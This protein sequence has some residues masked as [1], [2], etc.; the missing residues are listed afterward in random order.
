ML[1]KLSPVAGAG[2]DDIGGGSECMP[3]TR[4][5]VLAELMAWAT[6]LD[7]PPIY[8]LTGLAGTGK[9]AIA[10]SFA[11]LL[12]SQGLLGATFFCS[13]GSEARSTVAEIIPTIAF[14]LS[15][16]SQRFAE[17]AIHAIKNAPGVS[18]HHR[19]SIFQFR[20]LILEPSQALAD[21]P[22]PVIIIDALD[23]CS[24]IDTTRE[25]LGTL[26]RSGSNPY[27]RLK[28]FITSRPEPHIETVFGPEVVARRLR[29]RDVE[30]VSV[31]AD[32]EKYLKKKLGEIA[33]RIQSPGWPTPTDISDLVNRTGKLFIFAFTAVQYLSGETLSRHEIQ[34]RLRNILSASAPSKIQTAVIDTLYS[35][36]IDAAWEGKES[37]EKM[38][39]KNV[40]A[41]LICLREPL[42][43][44]GIS[45]LLREDPRNLESILA[46]F[47][48]VIDMPGSA[49]VPIVIFHASFSDY[50]TDSRRSGDNALSTQE[51]H[52]VLALQ[53]L[54]CMNSLLHT[55]MCSIGRAY[56][57]N[58]VTE[59]VLD[60]SVP[61]HLRYA[62]IHW[63]THLPLMP[64]GA[65]DSTLNS[66][67]QCWAK[68]HILHW[69]EC[70]SLIDKL[71]LAPDALR[72]ALVFLSSQN[73][74]KI[75]GLLEEVLRMLP[76]IFR[77][78]SLYPLEVYHSAL[79]WLPMA[80]NLRIAYATKPS[81]ALTG[82][83]QEW[84][85]CEQIFK[86]RSTCYSVAVSPVGDCVV[87]ATGD[88][89][90]YIWVIN[91]GQIRAELRGHSDAV[92]SVAY[93]SHAKTIASGSK[94]RTVR[95]WNVATAETE[96]E[97]VGHRDAV[98][99]V[100]FSSNGSRL[101]SAS[102][103]T[104]TMVWNVET[105]DIE[106]ILGGH[107]EP[108]RSIAFSV[109]G[110]TLLSS[111]EDITLVRI[112]DRTSGA[113]MH[114]L[115]GHSACVMSIAF[116][117]DGHHLASGSEDQTVRIWNVETAEMEQQLL[118]HTGMVFSVAFS[119]DGDRLISASSDRTVRI[120]NISTEKAQ[121]KMIL[122]SPWVWSVGFTPQTEKIYSRSGDNTVRIWN[123]K[124][125]ELE[126][127][128][129]E[130]ALGMN[131]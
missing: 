33:R 4:V 110:A 27:N 10:R 3:G 121:S 28:F 95:L 130:A 124:T 71:H 126:Q 18:F 76:Q 84:G 114:D 103:D 97:L 61:G 2:Y 22:I 5:G 43:L 60:I 108:V 78:A 79:E 123:A 102:R 100:A 15:Y 117:R 99:S 72:Q 55:N 32:I 36:I 107:S 122:R 34:T 12:D 62:A 86:H 83:D 48:S 23:E 35:Q 13:R 31:R 105:G 37:S 8:F 93:A 47:H 26:I 45:G 118:G 129:T 58:S 16:H 109:D 104:T 50:I 39:R 119:V 1:E 66:E 6:D 87:C 49:D 101:V 29:L 19:S 70:L 38:A 92:T 67:L 7:S 80:S 120:W 59:G 112:W 90:A 9:S 89:N 98:L 81:C 42:A 74:P 75:E 14:R 111:S 82:L 131:S 52:A 53:C 20:T 68:T 85:N 73:C 88:N 116:S 113:I 77:F 96:R 54:K 69:L 115:V 40:L 91:T 11:R 128:S 65:V 63:G 21:S 44:T 106:A 51:H 30:D 24:G 46:D 17:A 125:G 94:D 25:L 56:S 64:L 127:K 41:T 57:V